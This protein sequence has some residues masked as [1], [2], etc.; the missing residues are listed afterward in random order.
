MA[1]NTI[2]TNLNDLFSSDNENS[3]RSTN[4]DIFSY[5]VFVVTVVCFT[6]VDKILFQLLIILVTF[7]IFS[8]RTGLCFGSLIFILYNYKK[9]LTTP[10]TRYLAL[11]SSIL[12]IVVIIADTFSDQNDCYLLV[13]FVIVNIIVVLSNIYIVFQILKSEEKPDPLTVFDNVSD[14]EKNVK[15][16]YAQ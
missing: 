5:I 13:P 2:Q 16:N 14:T 15:L 1:G 11:F 9:I 6:C 7:F 10:V 12:S 3:V 4:K 8:Q